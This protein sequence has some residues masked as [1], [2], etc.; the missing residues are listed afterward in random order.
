MIQQVERL[1]PKLHER[2]LRDPKVLLQRHIELSEPV[3]QKDIP[4]GVAVRVPC[5]QRKR[6]HIE[7]RRWSGIRDG[8]VAYYGRT[9]VA[10]SRVRLI[11]RNHRCKREPGAGGQ[12]TSNSPA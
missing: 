10:H 4:P 5:R 12:D 3:R 2:G 8:C 9:L 1:S 6:V 7:P 11:T